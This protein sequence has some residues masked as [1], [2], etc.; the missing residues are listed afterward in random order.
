MTNRGADEKD[1]DEKDPAEEATEL[2]DAAGAGAGDAG[3][4]GS[5]PE[6]DAADDEPARATELAALP[7]QAWVAICVALLVVGV[8]AGHFL[9]GGTGT[10]SLNGRTALSAGELDSTIATYTVGG[11][12][13]PVTAREVLEEMAGGADLTANDDG[14][15]DVPGASSVLSYVQN[16]LII[17]DAHDRG[18]S[19]SDD[20]I[21]DFANQNLGTDDLSSVASAYG[22]SE[23]AV[24]STIEQTLLMRKLQDEVCDT[25][26][27]AAPTEPTA[28]AEGAED[29]PTADYASYV[30][31]LAGD[32]WDADADTWAR[33]DGP[34][35]AALS[36]YDISSAGATY[37]AA[38]A[39]YG[40]ATSAYQS[41]YAQV[42]DQWGAYTSS[43]L[44]NASIQIGTLAE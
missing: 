10:V 40:V 34:Y 11:Q 7:T 2:L 22:M 29:T 13:T 32:E 20:E 43:L 1:L 23:D 28:P 21:S 4:D 8:L 41:A 16:Q 19:V 18:L 33:T 17:A 26:L 12:T 38:E 5:G 30:I 25:A 42:S 39:A 36:G 44:S 31:G 24:R 15:Y 3:A 37:E 27:P 14:T 6:D 35:Y 9:L